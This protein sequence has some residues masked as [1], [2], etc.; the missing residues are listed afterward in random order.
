MNDSS[1][2]EWL[3]YDA[4]SGL[5]KWRKSPN[6]RIPSGSEAGSR[7]GRRV[8]LSIAGKRY[9]AHRVAWFFEYGEWPHGEIDHINGDPFD[10][11][12][13]NLRDVTRSVNAQNL[14][15]AR[16]NSTTGF[17]GV[18]FDKNRTRSPYVAALVINGKAMSL[19]CFRTPQEAH[20]VYLAAK[21]I[22]HE[23]NTL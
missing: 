19:G 14:K 13:T 11:R 22:H 23:G 20:A 2:D 1:L 9:F 5:F 6:R 4:T 3:T 16:S 7:V 8:Q 21:R 10:N 17:L 15:K 18:R 12:I